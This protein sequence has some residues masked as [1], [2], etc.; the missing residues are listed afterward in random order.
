MAE[1]KTVFVQTVERPARRAVIKRG[2]KAADYFA[3]CEEVG[4]DVWGLLSSIPSIVGEP[5]CMWL[6][7]AYVKPGTSTYVQG[8]EVSA[9]FSEPLPAGLEV[10]DLPACKY[11]MF[12]GAP[13]RE[14]DYAQAIEQVRE[15]VERYDP[16][17]L[18]CEWDRDNPRIQLEPIGMRG[19]IELLPVK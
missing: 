15:A 16:A 10:I 7:R 19:Y 9:D 6:P 5:V 2:V 14:E 1:E 18:G 3:Y 13:F 8:A 11:L 4:C 17:P 12:Q